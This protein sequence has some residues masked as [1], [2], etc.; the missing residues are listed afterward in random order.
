MYYKERMAKMKQIIT[1]ALLL[2]IIATGYNAIND[3][4]K[5]YQ[6]QHL[7]QVE[8]ERCTQNMVNNPDLVCD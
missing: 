2:A 3:L 6:M 8:V 1:T 5:G 4:W 7:N